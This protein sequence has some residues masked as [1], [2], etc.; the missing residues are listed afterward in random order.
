MVPGA[1]RVA[2]WS[3]SRAATVASRR[4]V[5]Q[6]VSDAAIWRQQQPYRFLTA[7]SGTRQSLAQDH[8]SF[9]M[10]QTRRRL[11]RTRS[12]R[13]TVCQELR[14]ICSALPR[15]FWTVHNHPKVPQKQCVSCEESWGATKADVDRQSLFAHSYCCAH[16]SSITHLFNFLVAASSRKARATTMLKSIRKCRKPISRN[17]ARS[18]QTKGG[19]FSIEQHKTT[20]AT[21]TH[22]T[23]EDRESLHLRNS[24]VIDGE[25]RPISPV[26]GSAPE[27]QLASHQRS[28]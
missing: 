12:R 3:L 13:E 1:S 6:V 18:R 15:L 23:T 5:S 7:R 21:G 26:A 19:N 24:R 14:E 28:D 20:T 16:P 25:I 22:Q 4:G 9:W 2:T 8:F 17:R 27:P 10:S 11:C